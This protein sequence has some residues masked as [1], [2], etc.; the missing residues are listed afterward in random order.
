MKISPGLIL[1][2]LYSKD[3]S[4][5][6]SPE[7]LLL[8]CRKKTNEAWSELIACVCFFGFVSRPPPTIPL[9]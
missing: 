4:I 5:R 8:S 9:K 6:V 1:E 2:I 3:R 7:A